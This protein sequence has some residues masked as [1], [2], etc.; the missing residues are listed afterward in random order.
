MYLLKKNLRKILDFIEDKN[1][2]IF[3][4][5][6]LHHNIGDLLIFS[7]T[8]N[9]FKNNSINVKLYQS[10]YNIN[11]EKSVTKNTTII[12]HG[13]GNFGDIYDIHQKLRENI[14]QS[15]PHNKII[16]LPQTAFF[17]KNENKEASKEIFRAHS[18]VVMFARDEETYDIFNNF[19]NHAYLMPDMAH[20]LYDTLPKVAK[21][22]S[23]MY[24][25]RND[26]EKNPIQLQIQKEIQG[27]DSFDWIDFLTKKD[28]K[29]LRRVRK[30]TKINRK[31]KSNLL[32][33]VIFN[34]WI[35]HTENLVSEMSKLFSSHEEITTSRLH[36]HIL[37]CLVDVPSTIIDNSYGKNTAYYRLWTKGLE[38][39]SIWDEGDRETD[40]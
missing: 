25:L 1:D 2:V 31:L 13:G 35:S 30:L 7:G 11:I 36:G 3:V 22:K 14:V 37:S 32:D 40:V 15:F 29:F 8:I 24:F 23:I 10:T 16:I 21:N 5:F 39:A 9:F 19:S 34:I 26:I 4:D 12:C 18:N 27:I 17:N 38:I 33:K 20:E 6:P 28:H